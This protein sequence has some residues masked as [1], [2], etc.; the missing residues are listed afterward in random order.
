VFRKGIIKQVANFGAYGLH[1]MVDHGNG[2]LSFYAHCK[3]VLFKENQYV[4]EG[5]IIALVGDTG[6]AT[7]PH[8][9][10][11]IKLNNEWVDPINYIKEAAMQDATVYSE[12]FKKSYNAVLIG[13]D[14]FVKLRPLADDYGIPILKWD[15]QTKTATIGGGLNEQVEKLA[16]E[17]CRK[18]VE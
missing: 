10:F 18:G 3:K 5:K 12:Y 15:N 13:N 11:G 6:W 14:T 2:V 4:D 1:V 7:G 8:L 9:H 16:D 17:F